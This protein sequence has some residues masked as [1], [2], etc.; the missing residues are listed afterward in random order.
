MRVAASAYTSHNIL[1]SSIAVC[2][3]NHLGTFQRSWRRQHAMFSIRNIT[4][5]N[6]FVVGAFTYIDHLH[7]KQL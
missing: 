6:E 3:R 7:R 2:R 1:R 4:F 5:K